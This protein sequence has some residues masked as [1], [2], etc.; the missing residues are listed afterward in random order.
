MFGDGAPIWRFLDALAVIDDPEAAVDAT[1]GLFVMESYPALALLSLDPAFVAA[2]KSGP[3][4]NPG[5]PTFS[6]NAWRAVRAAATREATRLG[7]PR[8]ATWCRALDPDAK[9]RKAKQDELDSILCLLIAVR[10]RRE[11]ASCVMIGDLRGG[12]IVTPVA[13]VV[14]GRLE[15]AANARGVAIG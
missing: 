15:M 10:W 9:P 6:Q 7:L 11:R 12:Y 14:R 3:R 13:D 8:V 2:G 5:R 4:Y 1:S